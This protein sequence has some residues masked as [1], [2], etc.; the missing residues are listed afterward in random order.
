MFWLQWRNEPNAG[1]KQKITF[2]RGRIK[3]KYDRAAEVSVKKFQINWSQVK[4]QV[5]QINS[6]SVQKMCTIWEQEQMWISQ[7]QM[8]T[9]HGQLCIGNKC[10]VQ[11]KGSFTRAS[12]SR[13]NFVWH[14]ISSGS[15]VI[16]SSVRI[17][18]IPSGPVVVVDQSAVCV[19]KI[20]EVSF[21]ENYCFC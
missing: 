4:H 6:D 12:G 8:W 1:S 9:S 11:S 19:P 5:Y 16:S 14:P 21:L 10:F 15:I 3:M 7:M 13:P 17:W 2:L 20:Q 18:F